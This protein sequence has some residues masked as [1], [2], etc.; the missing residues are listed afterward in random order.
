MCIAGGQTAYTLTRK[1]RISMSIYSNNYYVYAYLRATDNTPY[2]IGKG[3]NNRFLQSHPGVSIPKDQSKIVFLEK[4]LTNVGA[5]ALERRYIRWYGKKEDGGILLNRTDGGDGNSARRPDEWR[6]NH[7]ILMTGRKHTKETVM[8]LKSI[9][10][11]Y[12]KTDEYKNKMSMCKKGLPSKLKGKRGFQ[13]NS[14]KIKT[15]KGT[16]SSMREASDTL[17]VSL[18]YIKLWCDK[19][20]NGCSYS[21]SSS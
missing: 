3:K 17:G 7:K 14:K 13:V 19:N 6:E 10:R 16:F 5:C 12:M 9:D 2:Y 11:S 8:K 4:N 20:I 18:Y 21:S 15:P 1:D